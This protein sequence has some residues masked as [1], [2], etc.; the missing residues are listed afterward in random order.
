M[1]RRKFYGNPIDIIGHEPVEFE[2]EEIVEFVFDYKS[3]EKLV[4][5]IK[6]CRQKHNEGFLVRLY[7]FTAKPAA[8]AFARD[9]SVSPVVF[10]KRG[11]F[12]K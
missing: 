6:H 3:K 10:L 7:Q 1:K 2:V 9:N 8:T 5:G 4:C 12:R 11:L